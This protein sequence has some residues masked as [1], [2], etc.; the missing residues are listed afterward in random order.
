MTPRRWAVGLLCASAAL[1]GYELLL[2]RLL[3][4]AYWGHFAGMVISI[5]ML[6]IASSGLFLFFARDR[7]GRNPEKFFAWSAGLFGVAAPL[8]FIWS[9]RLPFTPFLLTWS[10]REYGLLAGRSLLFFSAFFLAGV[11]IGVPFVA[12]VLPM[13]RLYFCNMLGSG[14]PALPLLLAMNFAHPMRLLTSVAAVAIAVPVICRARTL[15]RVAWFV[16]AVAIV[17]VI[18][19]T[20]FRYSE[21]KDL[22]KTLLLPD[23]RVVEERYRWDGIV[24]IVESPH[25][26]H[27]P[28]LSLNFVGTVPP[29]RIVF[30]D[31]GAMTLAFAPDETL[32]NSDFLRMMPEA[33][34][35]ALVPTASVL[36]FY[37]GTADFL[38]AKA[39]G[40]RKVTVVDDSAARVEAVRRLI[41]GD[42]NFTH[43]DPRQMLAS[44]S[45][46]V[47]VIAISLLGTH[48]TSTAGA[49][50]LDASYLLTR[51]GFAR[52]F[53]RLTPA[54]HLAISTWV[55]NPARSGIRLAA[56]AVE[57]LRAAG[58]ENPSEHLIAIRSWATLSI[59][60]SRQRFSAS[61][62]DALKAFCDEHSFDLVWY[63]GID[64]AETN[65]INVIPEDPY[66]QAFAALVGAR[67]ESFLARSPFALEPP[68]DDRPFFSQ[69]FRW[70]AVPQ[71]MST[72]GLNWLPFVE[73][74]YI[75]HV[76]TLL[77]VTVLGFLLLIVPCFLTPARPP[78]RTAVVFFL[79]GVAYMFV[80]IWAI[81]KLSHFV[82]HPLLGSALVLSAMLIA[83][84]AGA[85][86]L[87]RKTDERSAMKI[88]LVCGAIALAIGLFPL[89]ISWLFPQ[90]T[91]LRVAA[92]VIWLAIPAFFMGF[93]FPYSLARLT[94]QSDV[95]WALALNGFGSVIG[96]LLA[97]LIAVHFGLLVLALMAVLGYT[98]VALL[99]R[100]S[101]ATSSA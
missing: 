62:I 35:L 9:Q 97:T 33:F 52:A 16:A 56:L 50:S 6:G 13:G 75:L 36:H 78:V 54:G 11:A 79:L 22:P 29:A 68:T 70:A 47:D 41:G 2:M 98:I 80:Q 24:Q 26:R 100:S 18:V 92:A 61:S 55:E 30:T 90:S 95:P 4:L 23:S 72:M 60:V 7:V 48:G 66:Y 17:A 81:L 49:A 21:Y 15:S 89:L 71:W 37:G 14:L 65:R 1:L 20:P 67:A 53:D 39:L 8:A 12:R 87:T 19:V 38:R 85:V 99:S 77:V 34:S 101:G 69:Y 3:A 44:D 93:P 58:L 57:T 28:G 43:G 83:S 74:G 94:R 25:T 63:H 84:G 5:A 40:A 91:W 31:A 51:E 42:A 88:A 32:A 10:G 86:V 76:A 46:A 64:P 82:A 73:W 59:F 45:A 96:A 27:V